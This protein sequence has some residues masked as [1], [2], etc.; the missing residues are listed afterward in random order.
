[1]ELCLLNLLVL[2]DCFL[3]NSYLSVL[4]GSLSHV[5][6]QESPCLFVKFGKI[7]FVLFWNFEISLFSLGRFQNFKKVNLLNLSQI[8]LLN[9]WLL[10][11]IDFLMILKGRLI[12]LNSSN[13]KSE[14]WRMIP[15]YERIFAFT[16]KAMFSSIE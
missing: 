1:M 12:R 2:I 9:A 15:K 5:I 3:F 4:F 14:I 16:G 10:V 11:L 7:Y 8:S 13:F 6:N